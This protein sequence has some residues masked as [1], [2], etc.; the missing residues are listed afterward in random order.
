MQQEIDLLELGYEPARCLKG[1]NSRRPDYRARLVAGRAKRGLEPLLRERRE[2]NN[3]WIWGRRPNWFYEQL[4][5]R[6]EAQI[7]YEKRRVQV[8]E[9]KVAALERQQAS[10]K[11]TMRVIEKE[12]KKAAR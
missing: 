4:I 1:E 6:L 2:R 12:A 9:T 10:L 8:R 5:A 3:A 7:E 11:S